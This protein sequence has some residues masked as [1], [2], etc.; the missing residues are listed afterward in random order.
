MTKRKQE[1]RKK[2]EPTRPPFRPRQAQP[3]PNPLHASPPPDPEVIGNQAV[4]TEHEDAADD[5]DTE[6]DL[7]FINLLPERLQERIT[8]FL[9]ALRAPIDEDNKE[10]ISER[11]EELMLTCESDPINPEEVVMTCL[12]TPIVVLLAQ[13][14]SWRLC[15]NADT[16]RALPRGTEETTSDM[17]GFF[18]Q[19]I[20]PQTAHPR[21]VTERGTMLEGEFQEVH[22]HSPREARSRTS[23][24]EG[25]ASR[26]V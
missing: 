7:T 1:T 17:V 9:D 3:N 13:C 25:N 16:H 11:L 4:D 15:R 5:G 26:H 19:G 6:D 23:S 18:I 24:H 21:L 10:A 20:M 12:D 8:A 14:R 22:C 2:R